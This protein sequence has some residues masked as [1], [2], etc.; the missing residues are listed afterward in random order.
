MISGLQLDDKTLQKDCELHCTGKILSYFNNE[1]IA[2][3]KY[4]S[5]VVLENLQVLTL[6][7]NAPVLTLYSAQHQACP[8]KRE[9]G[10]LMYLLYAPDFLQLREEWALFS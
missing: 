10:V 5:S 2:E 4:V 6:S 9:G 8:A 7:T 3:K 1:Q